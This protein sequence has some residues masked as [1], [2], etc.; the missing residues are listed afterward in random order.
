MKI[1]RGGT[2]RPGDSTD[3]LTKG[4]IIAYGLGGF[5]GTLPNQ[6]RMQFHMNFMTDVAGLN[7]G[8]VGIWTMLLS[9][10]DAINDPIVGRLVDRTET[11]WGKYRPHMI[12][13][14]LCWAATILLL[15]CVPSFA[16]AGRMAYYVVVMALFAV[17][18]TQFTVPWQALNSVMSRDVHQRNLLLTSRQLVGAVATS[19][20]GLFAVPVVS[21]FQNARQGWIA[22]AAIVALLCASC[23]CCAARS[24][25]R[26]DYHGSIPSPKQMHIREQLGQLLRNKAVICAGLLLGI[27]N[28]GISAS[29]AMSMYYMKY[30]VGNVELLT[31]I[32]LINIVVTL[33]VIPLLP[34]LLRRFGKQKMLVSG[35]VLQGLSAVYQAILREGATQ[36]Q[37]ILM[38]TA[39]TLGLTCANTCCF[40]LIPDCTDYTELHFGSA[41]AGLINATGTFMRQF[42]GA[43]SSL[44]VGTLMALVGYDADL[45]VTVPIRAMILHIK[46]WMPLVLLAL[47]LV[48]IRQ[49]PITRAY[50]QE[51]RVQLRERQEK[52]QL[53]RQSADGAKSSSTGNA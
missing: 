12:I 15:F 29:A 34:R 22:A 24:A 45:P 46:V 8:A 30:I 41:Q 19:A 17:F 7:I 51:M 4:E 11:R 20:V 18:Y 48:V 10:W 36:T 1:R 2:V 6:F 43:F 32:S 27:V 42:F 9:V 53:S 40:A 28:L 26:M 25:R 37:V 44:I 39:N 3:K 5:A 13:G 33:L 16:G 49:Y 52:R 14:S 21:R 23:G 35:M 31:V 50:G 47:T 38:S